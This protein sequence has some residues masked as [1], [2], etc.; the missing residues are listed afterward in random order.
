M[1][2][3]ESTSDL[4][5][6]VMP[7]YNCERF[8]AQTIDSV[9]AQTYPNWELLVTDDCSSDGTCR[10][11]EGYLKIDARIRLFRLPK[12]SGAAVARNNS[13]REAKGRYIAF[14]DSDDLWLPEK[15]AVQLA[16]MQEYGYP[17]TCTSYAQIDER[18]VPLNK[19]IR[20]KKKVDYNRLLL[21]CPVGNSSVVYDVE[22]IGKIEVPDIRKR[23]DDALWLRMLR[24][25]KYIRGIEQPLM[26]YRIRRNSI[27]HNKLD[28]I[29]YHWTLYRN[30]EKLSVLRSSFH[31]GY[32]CFLKIFGIK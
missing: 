25:E 28:L 5:S 11:V 16:F 13:I 32:W 7:S 8:I 27:S 31:I 15:L 23:N 10:I 2:H 6:I 18:G 29:K 4:V 20:A 22:K 3:I 24:H 1:Q 14:L 30:I 9:L 12:N 26:L 21:D 19:I 17:F